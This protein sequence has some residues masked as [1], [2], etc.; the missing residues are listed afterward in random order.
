MEAARDAVEEGRA[1]ELQSLLH[2]GQLAAHAP[3]L[4]ALFVQVRACGRSVALHRKRIHF[5]PVLQTLY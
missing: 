2:E 1:L 3:A 5:I 4:R